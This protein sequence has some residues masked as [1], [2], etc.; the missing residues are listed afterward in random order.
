MG[1]NLGKIIK[2]AAKVAAPVSALGLDL[3]RGKGV[4]QSAK[5]FA[6]NQGTQAKVAA[7]L[8]PV[9]L[10]GGVGAGGLAAGGAGPAAGTTGGAAG[11]GGGF[12]LLGT[13]QKLGGFA[14]DNSDALLAAGSLISGLDQQRKGDRMDRKSIAEAERLR[15]LYEPLMMSGREGLMNPRK[16]DLSGVYAGSSNP[17]ARR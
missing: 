11:G 8:L 10:S 5:N 1:I 9:A 13:V 7:T 6:S 15:A 12:D 3:A 4:K 17:F 14:R 16:I 2:K